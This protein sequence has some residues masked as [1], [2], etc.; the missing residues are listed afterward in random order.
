[1]MPAVDYTPGATTPAFV[2]PLARAVGAWLAAADP[3]RSP[4][5]RLSFAVEVFGAPESDQSL[6]LVTI[7]DLHV[8]LEELA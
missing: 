1:M 5:S 2:P 3:P 4:G 7:R 8:A 6:P